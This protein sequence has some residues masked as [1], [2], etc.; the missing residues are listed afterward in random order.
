[1]TYSAG[2]AI[3][4]AGAIMRIALLVLALVVS[5]AP[6]AASAPPANAG[7]GQKIAA[8]MTCYGGEGLAAPWTR[9]A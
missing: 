8:K 1:L 7:G 2:S 9:N 5:S 3:V 6:P 4:F